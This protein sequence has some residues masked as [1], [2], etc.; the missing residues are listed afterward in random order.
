MWIANS[1]LIGATAVLFLLW[2]RYVCSLMLAA[3]TPRDFRDAVAR[4]NS[5]EF[6][7]VLRSLESDEVHSTEQLDA[8]VATLERDFEVVTYLVRHMGGTP[9]ADSGVERWMLRVDYRVQALWYRVMRHMSEVWA[10]R[11]VDQM[12]LII[13]HFADLIG[14]RGAPS[15]I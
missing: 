3:Q 9:G 5:L 10:R 6:A 14:E 2:C 7:S 13:C 15:R 11:K 4:A 1:F 8:F 12:A